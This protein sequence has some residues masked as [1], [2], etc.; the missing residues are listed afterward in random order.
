M[1]LSEPSSLMRWITYYVIVTVFGMWS[2]QTYSIPTDT[3]IT[4]AAGLY[5]FEI[6]QHR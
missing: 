3:P 1:Q 2:W 6:D 5:A 4:E